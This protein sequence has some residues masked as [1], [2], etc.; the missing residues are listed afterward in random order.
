MKILDTTPIAD[1]AQFP[2]KKGTLQ[3]IQDAYKDIMRYLVSTLVQ[4]YDPSVV[5]IFSGVVNSAIDPVFQISGGVVFYNGEFFEVDAVNFSAPAANTAIFKLDTSQYTQDADPVTFTDL[6]ARNVHNIRKITIVSGLSG[7]GLSNFSQSI[8]V[9]FAIPP[10][11]TIAAST[12]PGN[13]VVVDDNA[14][15]LV[16]LF[17]PQPATSN[18]PVLFAGE[19]QLGNPNGGTTISVNFG[20]TLTGVT[21]YAVVGSLHSQGSDFIAD[22]SITW[23]TKNETNSGF[24]ICFA[25]FKLANQNVSLRYA[26]VKIN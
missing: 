26:I 10:A 20:V 21:K 18:Y 1:N 11:V 8:R 19:A 13:Q 22:S 4:S 12:D 16:K 25:Q 24:Q 23:S 6:V 15:P 3:F 17:V 7:S 5:Y 9:N 14:Y 2:V